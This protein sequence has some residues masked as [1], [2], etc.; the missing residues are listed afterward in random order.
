MTPNEILTS[1]PLDLLF[2]NRNQQYG[3]YVLRKNYYTR[4]W[5]SL[6]ISLSIF[7][8]LFVMLQTGTSDD[9]PKAKEET[10]I[11]RDFSPPKIKE[12]LI[13]PQQTTVAHNTT[14]QRKYIDR[15][16][17]VDNNKQVE[18]FTPQD[19][20]NGAMPGTTSQPGTPGNGLQF[21][22]RPIVQD[23][24]QVINDAEPPLQSEPE[25]PGGV[26]AWIAFLQRNLRV[27]EDL[28]EGEKKTVLVRFQVSTEGNVTGFEILQ[29]GGNSYDNEVIRVLKK[30]P[31]WKPAI[32]NNVPVARYFTQPV[33]FMGVSE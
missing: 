29:S 8:L 31:R 1:S 3:A 2:Q 26:R 12:P 22:P 9:K 24:P 14:V 7:P 33:T 16:N 10:V 21:E 23:K 13:K 27:P 32:Q 30:M 5:M 11:I 18:I 20:L 28:G 6:G 4:L 17:I 15:I 25:Y 19:Q